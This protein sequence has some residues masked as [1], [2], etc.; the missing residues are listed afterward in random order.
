MRKADTSSRKCK[1]LEE[2]SESDVHDSSMEQEQD[3]ARHDA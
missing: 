1:Y 3:S 2:D